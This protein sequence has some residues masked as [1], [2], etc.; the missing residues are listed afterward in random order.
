MRESAVGL[1]LYSEAVH[2][3]VERI[4]YIGSTEM[5]QLGRSLH[6]NGLQEH[7]LSYCESV[8]VFKLRKK[9]RA[10]GEEL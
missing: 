6:L 5:C 7:V 2:G 8:L 9:Y 10:E 3:T 4:L 1:D